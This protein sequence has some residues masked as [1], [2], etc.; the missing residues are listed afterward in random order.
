[1]SKRLYKSREYEKNL[2]K[3]VDNRLPPCCQDCKRKCPKRRTCDQHQQWKQFR[4]DCL[5]VWRPSQRHSSAES[6]EESLYWD[7]IEN[8]ARITSS[9]DNWKP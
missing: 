8:G 4:R 9:P 2:A 5:K 7:A 6:L 1:V 3:A